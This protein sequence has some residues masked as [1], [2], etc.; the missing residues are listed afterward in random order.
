MYLFRMQIMERGIYYKY[1]SLSNFK[2]FVDIIINQ[3]LYAA[4]CSNMNDAMGGVYYSCG[5][6]S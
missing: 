1:R 4:N 5:L 2:N 3:K 6:Q